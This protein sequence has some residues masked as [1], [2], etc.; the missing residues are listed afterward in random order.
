MPSWNIPETQKSIGVFDSGIGGLTVVHALMQH[1]PQENITYFGDTARVPYGS[2]SEEVVREYAFED[3]RFLLQQ[4][5]KIIVV[6]CNTVSAVAIDDLKAHFDIPIIGMIEPGA[7]AA[8]K[9]SKNGRIGVIGTLATI[10]SESYPRK[11]KECKSSFEI[12]STPCPLFVPLAEEGWRTHP[13][14][15][16]IAEEYLADLRK[17][18]IDTLILGCT[19]YPILRDVIQKHVGPQVALID[20]GEA[21]A[22]QV[23]QMLRE[24]N[25]LNTSTAQPNYSF[26][27]SDVPQKFK[28]LGELFLQKAD[29]RVTK[30]HLQ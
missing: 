9:A 19:H 2:K 10:G 17:E 25:L 18:Q 13:A 28:Q 20:S 23:E 21:A 1:L 11:L 15:D 3:T 12:F 30:V 22:I 5:V 26:F 27:V 6:A 4:G 7:A 8:C 24:K 16:L 14:S 29:L